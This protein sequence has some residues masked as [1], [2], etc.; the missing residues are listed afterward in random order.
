MDIE[1]AKTLGMAI[2]VGFGV[3]FVLWMVG[4][5]GGGD[6]KLMGA[7]S[8]WLGFDRTLAV[9]AMSTLAVLLGTLAVMVFKVT[10]KGLDKAKT[11]LAKPKAAGVPQ[12]RIMTFA[13]PVAVAT[14]LVLFYFSFVKPKLAERHHNA[15]GSRSNA[16]AGQQS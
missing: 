7:I 16:V 4:G 3:L 14:W 9:L 1:V 10:F 2:A 13:F 6:V 12:R 5:G 11:E 8:V 15:G